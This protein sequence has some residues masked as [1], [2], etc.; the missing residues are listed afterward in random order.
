VESGCLAKA[1]PLLETHITILTAGPLNTL[2]Y[3]FNVGREDRFKYNFKS[4][5]ARREGE[6]GDHLNHFGVSSQ[7]SEYQMKR[8]CLVRTVN[9][10][11]SPEKL[12]LSTMATSAES[13]EGLT[14][15]PYPLPPAD[16]VQHVD[17]SKECRMDQPPPPCP[18]P[19][20]SRGCSTY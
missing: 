8:S 4:I 14:S 16:V 17:F 12:V 3:A 2:S 10:F 20:A 18:P 7:G 5:T 15:P 19:P 11:I 13:A 9:I 1:E 6:G